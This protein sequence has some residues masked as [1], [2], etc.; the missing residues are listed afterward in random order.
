MTAATLQRPHVFRP[1][2]V[3]DRPPLLLLHGTGDDE[4][5]LLPL[6]E[7]LSPGAAL[8]S[9]RGTVLEGSANR[10]FRRLRE[11]VFDEDD[12]RART[13]ELADFVRAA[14]AEHGLAPAYAVGF[15]N[16]ANTAVALLLRHPDL[17]A[18]AVLVASVPPFAEPPAA[19]LTGRRVL[20]SNGERDPMARPEQ[21]A[22]LVAQLRERGADVEL[23]THSGGHQLGAGA[24]ACDAGAAGG[25]SC[26]HHPHPDRHT[27][28]S[29]RP[30]A[31]RASP[32]T[33]ART[34]PVRSIVAMTSYGPLVTAASVT[35]G[36]PATNDATSSARPGSACMSS[37]ACGAAR[38]TRAAWPPRVAA[39][40]RERYTPMALKPPS[41]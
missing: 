40:L 32:T 36:S 38:V 25:V 6:G 33:R 15:S 39:V 35:A 2:T 11:G 30:G 14:S 26:G 20:V 5:G 28:R 1:A 27:R 22:A 13:D 16:G 37:S 3:P 8:L 19:D 12:L 29:H 9:P 10:F 24:P 4:H 18:G 23:L 31:R 7:A 21:T 34:S 17:L 41:T